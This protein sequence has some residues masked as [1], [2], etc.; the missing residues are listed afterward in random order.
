MGS[1]VSEVRVEREAVKKKLY[2]VI[3]PGP[4][5]VILPER[6]FSGFFDKTRSSF[7]R[8]CQASRFLANQERKCQLAVLI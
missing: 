3:M 4:I 6:A 2:F 5:H 1:R 7:W 8:N